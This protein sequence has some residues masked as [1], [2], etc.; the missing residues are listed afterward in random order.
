MSHDT[1]L[2]RRRE[3]NRLAQRRFR[4]RHNS[5]NK[6]LD[7]ELMSLDYSEDSLAFHQ[8]LQGGRTA[9]IQPATSAIEA[10]DN[11]VEAVLALSINSRSQGAL[12]TDLTKGPYHPFRL[13][14]SSQPPG[15]DTTQYTEGNYSPGPMIQD[16]GSDVSNTP[17]SQLVLSPLVTS[18]LSPLH[19]AAKRGHDKIVALLLQ[20]SPD[21]NEKD[22]DG[23]TPLIHAV[24]GGHQVVVTALLRGAAR[25]AEAD[26]EGRTPL[27]WAV[28]RQHSTILTLLLEACDNQLG[29]AVNAYNHNSQTPLSLA[30]ESGFEEGVRI[31][32]RYGAQTS[33]KAIATGEAT[34]GA[35]D[36]LG[37]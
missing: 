7:F 35:T 12:G 20:H 26:A 4:E 25:V 19:I 8:A 34:G 28:M 30:A 16:T 36:T 14:P 22:S 27:H 2:E 31:L 29:A 1:D 6:S 18:W 3:R 32:L 23:T 21:C 13:L 24:R 5:K 10:P 17:V 33:L 9:D 11:D 15:P 37:S